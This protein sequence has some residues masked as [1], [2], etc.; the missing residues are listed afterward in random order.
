M[1]VPSCS[2]LQ[3]VLVSICFTFVLGLKYDSTQSSWNLNQNETATDPLDYWGSWEDV[4]N[5]TYHASPDNWR[6]PFY[7]LAL[8]RFANGD[9]TND[10]ANGTNFEHDWMSNQFRYGGDAEGLMNN[11]DYLQGL[12]IKVIYVIGS[13]FINQPWQSD[14]YSPLDLT[15]L[16]HHHGK[17]EDWRN[18]V[19]A[20][21]ERD[22]FVV[23]ENTMA[24]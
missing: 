13:P 9:P 16:D 21:H 11:L 14:G 12:G 15:L 19:T 3:V 10:E 20:I 8:D 5:H 23:M 6:M 22:M 24:T 1:P 4:E 2:L 18:L 7:T 17:I